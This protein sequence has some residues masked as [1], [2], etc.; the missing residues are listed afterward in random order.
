MRALLL[1][2]DADRKTIATLTDI[3]DSALPAGN[4]TVKVEYSTLNY[5][6]ALAVT[7]RG[8]IAKIWPLV[9]GIDVAGT[10]EASDDPAWQPG[11]RVVVNGWGLGETHWGGLAQKARLDSKWLLKLPAAYSARQAMAIGTAGYTAA[12]CLLALQRHGTKPG[13]GEILVTGAS[14]GV[15]SIAVRLLSRMGY[16]V[17]ASTGRPQEADHLKSLGATS[18]VDRNTLSAPGKALQKERWAGTVDTVGSH[19][20]ANACAATK[21][22]GAVAGGG[23]GPGLGFPSPRAPVIRRGVTRYGINC[24]YESNARRAQCYELL[25]QHLDA[26]TLDG[27]TTEIGL[28]EAIQ[29]SADLL[30]GKIHGRAVVDVNR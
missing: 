17:A 25:A 5:K 1:N 21:W 10:V 30:D 20:L 4:V 6:D 11:D 22:N 14:G 3:A 27:M 13:D 15:G 29:K 18:I 12:L 28:S 9:P 2:Q 24:V 19:T 23:R 8:A 7:G 16:E 26:A